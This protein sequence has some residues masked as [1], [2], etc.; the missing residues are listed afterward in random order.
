MNEFAIRGFVSAT[1]RIPLNVD[2]GR[3]ALK[4]AALNLARL[5][6]HRIPERQR[7][8]LVAHAQQRAPAAVVPP[9]RGHVVQ[10][11]VCVRR[12]IENDRARQNKE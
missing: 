1:R 3:L 8:V 9:Q 10:L 11:C 6:A 2:D 12:R 5:V 4:L 7:T